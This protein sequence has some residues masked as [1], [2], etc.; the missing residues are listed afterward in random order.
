V[1]ARAAPPK[2]TPPPDPEQAEERE[3][4]RIVNSSIP[5]DF[6]AFIRSHQDSSHIDQARTRAAEL[7][8]NSAR[9]AEQAAWDR[10]DRNR[11]DQ[12]AEFLSRYSSGAHA[13]EARADMAE[14]DRKATEALN[15]QR[16]RDSE[17]KRAADEQARRTADEQAV[18]RALKDLE[19]A[20]NNKNLAAVRGLWSEAPV[21]MLSVTFKEAKDLKFELQPSGQATI[22]GNSASIVCT[23]VNTY[24]AKGDNG[25]IQKHSEQ[26]RVTLT[27]EAS[28]WLI[29]SIVVQ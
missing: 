10:V 7:R 24:R 15:A 26:V 29:R 6:D 2:V 1:V 27:R 28:T 3:W 13:P 19:G 14:I 23:R 17:T 16:L 11:R 9:Q 18:F 5:D 20:Y 21:N 8:A 4:A 25:P 22:S 12:L